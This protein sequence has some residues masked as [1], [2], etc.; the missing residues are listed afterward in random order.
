MLLGLLQI[1]DADDEATRDTAGDRGGVTR[2]VAVTG[3]KEGFITAVNQLVAAGT[4]YDRVVV[5]THGGPGFIKFGDDKIYDITLRARFTGNYSRLFP[6]Y[7]RMYFNGCSVGDGGDLLGWGF[8]ET[9]GKI[10]LKGGGRVFAHTSA[11]YAF[12]GWLPFIGSHTVHF[13]G[14]T[15]YVDIGPGGVV[16]KRGTFEEDERRLR[17][18]IEQDR[19]RRGVPRSGRF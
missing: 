12:P 14:D 3:G 11:G 8:L 10:F 9:A 7:T 1:Y 16:I 15:R 5:E 6:L 13:S 2:S 19:A 4:P 18:E 17:A